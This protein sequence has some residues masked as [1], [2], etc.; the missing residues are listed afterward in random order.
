MNIYEKLGVREVINA[1][2]TKTHLG[3]T[4]PDSR[5][6][7]AM[8]EA[9][10]SFVVM[11]ELIEKAGEIIAEATGA[12]DGLVT[13]GSSAGMTLAAAACIM[14]GSELENVDTHP[15]ERVD[16]DK[17]WIEIIQR[18]P[19][20]SWTHNELIVQKMHRHSFDH[21]YKIAGA[22]LV[23]VGSNQGCS[24]KEIETAIT[25]NTA[26]IA[27]TARV[28]NSPEKA[29][30]NV[31]LKKVIELAHNHDIPVIVDAASELP[32]QSKLS[33]YIDEGADLVIISGGKHMGGP[34]DTGILCG[35]HDLIKLAKLQAAPYR[36]IGRG[37]KVDRT[38]IVGLI[39]ALKIYLEKD[40]KVKFERDKKMVKW[41][42]ETL[43]NTSNVLQ[44]ESVIQEARKRLFTFITLEPNIAR[45]L[46]Y[47][48]R[49][50]NPSI[51]IELQS[52]GRVEIDPSNLKDGEEKIVISNIKKIL[53][54]LK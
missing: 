51:W 43:T 10:R 30:K 50:N 52:I 48:L 35:R 38:Q 19:D 53:N 39:T 4:I 9:S 7:D 32:P 28:D 20:T 23:N 3:G 25:D 29:G 6:M 33:E 37:M 16:L 14:K 13:S 26:A 45:D 41:M 54:E 12:E 15:V 40:E 27:F 22:K 42:T 24:L 2:G 36:G 1:N 34:N 21:A 31:P 46:V 5:V 8:T 18:L 44:S 47:K 17:D 49:K 11:M